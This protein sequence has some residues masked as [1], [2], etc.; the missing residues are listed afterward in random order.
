MFQQI[1]A[2]APTW[3]N[4]PLRLALGLIFI[5]NG[6][7]KVFGVWGGKGL[8]EFMAGAPPLG[9]RP[10]WLWMGAAAFSEFIGG[11]LVLLG[12]LTR[13]GALMI[14]PVML[15]AI[16]GVLWG[17]GFFLPKGFEYAFALLCIA[18]ALVIAGGGRL[19]VDEKLMRSRGRR[20]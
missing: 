5:G 12:F 10:A 7:Q 3:I 4:L 11:V 2:T 16:I 15:V 9:L 1:I 19:S 18:L 14:V 20:R 13:L 8:N 17:G 6:S